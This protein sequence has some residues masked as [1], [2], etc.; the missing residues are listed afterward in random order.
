MLKKIVIILI[1]V[2]C[3][4]ACS[5]EVDDT[6]AKEELIENLKDLKEKIDDV[7]ND[8]EEVKEAFSSNDSKQDEAIEIQEQQANDA[9]NENEQIK[10]EVIS[11]STIRPEVKDAIDAY[12]NFID[13][14]CDFMEKYANDSSNSLAMLAQYS[15]LTAELLEF[16]EKMDK[17]EGDLTDAEAIY[18]LEVM[19][20]CSVKILKTVQ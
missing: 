2:F 17:L 8:F 1:C 16:D 20:R 3:L 4:T 7:K 19:N 12:E 18:Y 13:E 15:K 10:E 11:E 5:S 9:G 6:N 14:Y